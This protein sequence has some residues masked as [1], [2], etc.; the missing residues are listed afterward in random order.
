MTLIPEAAAPAVQLSRDTLHLSLVALL[1]TRPFA[2]AMAAVDD[3]AAG[4][5]KMLDRSLAELRHALHGGN[6]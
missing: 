6:P 5:L 4:R 1:H 3:E 2:A